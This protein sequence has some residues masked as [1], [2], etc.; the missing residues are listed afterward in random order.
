MGCHRNPPAPLRAPARPSG[1]RAALPL[2]LSP[3]FDSSGTRLRLC[4]RPALLSA[5]RSALLCSESLQCLLPAHS[6]AS[7]LPFVVVIS[8]ASR[9]RFAGWQSGC[10]S[11][12]SVAEAHSKPLRSLSLSLAC[13]LTS[14]PSGFHP[15]GS[16]DAVPGEDDALE[17]ASPQA[18]CIR[19]IS[20]HLLLLLLLF[21][22]RC[23]FHV[24]SPIP[25]RCRLLL[26][27]LC[28]SQPFSHDRLRCTGCTADLLLPLPSLRCRPPAAPSSGVCL[29]D[30]PSTVQGRPLRAHHHPHPAAT[31]R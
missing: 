12:L 24:S 18:H 11:S 28:S 14:P 22:R 10:C 31:I 1:W 23:A 9:A 20:Y 8:L 27:R 30:A 19:L 4:D 16:R 21:R 17:P 15:A 5:L 7:P 13:E 25:R 26:L 3:A 29:A 2:C 6:L